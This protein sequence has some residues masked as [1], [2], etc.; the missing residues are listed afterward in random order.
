MENT[1]QP[2]PETNPSSPRTPAPNPA[3]EQSVAPTQP[4]TEV[5][6]GQVGNETEVD[7]DR[8][9][10]STFPNNTPPERH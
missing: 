7:L 4:D 3:E 9:R 8:G 5:N 10:I 6:P 1:P 2:Q